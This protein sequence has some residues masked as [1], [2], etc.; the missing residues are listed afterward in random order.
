MKTW[1]KVAT[2]VGV[3]ILAGGIVWYSVNQANKDVVTVQTAHVGT[4]RLVSIVT[5]SGEVRPRTYSN[6]LA[7]GFGRITGIRVKEGDHVKKGDILMDIDR[8]QPAADVQAQAA[9]VQSLQASLDAS[10]AAYIQ[11]QADLKTQQANL[12]KARNDNERGENLIKNGII[13]AQQYDLYKS[14]YDAALSSVAS[15]TAHLAQTKAQ[16]AQAQ[17]LIAQS[18]ATRVHLQDVLNKTT[19]R[20]PLD[21]VVSYIAMRVGEDV[22]PGI[23]NST[24]SYLMTISDMSVVT[25]ETMVD[26]TDI[27]NL[28]VGQ[29]ATVTIDALPGQVFSGTVT[30][31]G[32]QAVLR[33]SG[34]ATTQSTTGSQE[35]RD[36]KTVV[37]LDNPP[38]SL[39]PGLSCTSKI[40]TAEKD[41]ALAI[42]IQALAMR[43]RKQLEEAAKL[44]AQKGQAGVTLAAAKPAQPQAAP[45]P[46][47]DDIQGVFVIRNGK[48]TF[49]EVQTG[50]SGVTDI[51][52]T[53]GLKTGDEIVTGSYKALRTLRPD[54]P[55][56]VDN[57]TPDVNNQ[58]ETT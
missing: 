18:A 12:E 25:S 41:S 49:V 9:L 28:R 14:T 34:L 24:G 35:A 45:D 38:V 46:N 36:F 42:P 26:E 23:Q 54:A 8:V 19:V 27:I 5:A 32:S 58:P 10:K 53:K 57:R 11:A 43:S 56:K 6:V 17:E 29:K 16:V 20:S 1:Q 51:E 50:I 48:A 13:P 2:G 37:T 55:V 7:E 44:A 21:G 33:S 31:V 52:I 3:V 47:G 4:E 22:V 15:A 30:E 40:V 39:R